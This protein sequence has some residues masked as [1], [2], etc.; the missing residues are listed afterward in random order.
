MMKTMAQ[1]GLLGALLLAA[2]PAAAQDNDI[3]AETVFALTKKVADWQIDTFDQQGRYRALPTDPPDWANREQYHD[4]EWHNGAL[5]AGMNQWR[6]V[7]DDRKY[8]DW[9]MA[10]GERN[11]WQLHQRPYHADDHVVGQFYLSFYE[12]FGQPGMMAG[13][14]ERFDW[15]LE[16]PKTGTLD[17]EAE[18][19]HAHDRWGW[20]D[21]LFMAP[22]VWARLAKIT[23][24]EKYLNFMDHEYH[25][26]YD[27]LWSEQDHLFWRD[28]SYFDQSEANGEDIFWSRGN[29][30]VFA[31]L[32]LMIPDL[33][34][35]WAGR[36]FY[37]DLYKEMAARLLTIQR[38]DG[39]WSMGLLGALEDYPVPETSGTAFFTFGLA[40]GINAGLLDREEYEP[41]V[42]RAWQALAGAVT[43]EGLLG[44]VQPV[45]AAPGESYPDYTEVYGVGAFLAAGSELYKLL[46]ADEQRN[47]N[48]PGAIRVFME[49]GGWCWFQDPR[50]LI[51]DGQLVMGGVAGNGSGDAA[52]GVYDLASGAI[53][54]R[55]TVADHFDRDD[56][57]S[58]ALYARPDG[59]LLAVY[60]RHGTENRHYYR[61]S[62]P[63]DFLDWGEQRTLVHRD[64]VTYANLHHLPDEG[65][66]YNFYRGLQWNPAFVTS[67][68]DGDTW[69]EEQHFILD[70]LQDVQR[71]Y[72]RYADN[73]R[74][75]IALAFTDAHPRDHGTS[76]Y[77]A[78][79][80]DGRYFNV[81]GT[82]IKHR[83][84]DGPLKPSEAEVIFRGGGGPF[85]DFTLSA[86]DSAWTSD[87]ALDADGHPHIAYTLYQGNT[88][89]RYRLASWDGVTWHDREIA[90]AGTRLYD[91]EASYTGLVALDPGEPA[92]VVISTDV[93][94]A[95]GERLNGM[96]HVYR[97][98]IDTGD[99]IENINWERLSP[100]DGNDH[101]RPIVVTG[102]VAGEDQRAILWLSGR[103]N[104]YIDYD[105]DVVGVVL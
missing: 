68:D 45:G 12:D 28:S 38:E 82:P 74:D 49:N 92:H 66:L 98:R 84:Q 20:C 55:V 47:A 24:D 39:T 18:D 101:L 72:V 95:T 16:N 51:R 56:H 75:T 70:E 25:V 13:V 86:E 57:N 61:V 14:Q 99:D 23:G 19:T 5:Y 7:A 33:P 2:G 44:H 4:L 63:G 102:V 31:G 50:A 64:R 79:Y 8:T 35:D 41:A 89:Q 34:A 15:I 30:W 32:A 67:T 85:R 26:T 96:H 3:T 22:P 77:Y 62:A 60:A 97:A 11:H 40:W 58:P 100:N 43:E 88:D 103:F 71:P 65:R 17:W 83:E 105:L 48:T 6:K 29:G 94:P 104:S 87:I 21:A 27:L 9:L 1:L 10:V 73:G 42:R 53:A 46:K 78:E 59:R 54:G 81:D 52:I 80:R 36:E 90:H 93:D 76:I 69:G 91:A 37:V